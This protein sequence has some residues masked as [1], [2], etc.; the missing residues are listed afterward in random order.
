MTGF[1]PNI[2]SINDKNSPL[3]LLEGYC[4]PKQPINARALSLGP[5]LSLSSELSY[6]A[7]WS[8]MAEIAL[9][10]EIYKQMLDFS[11]C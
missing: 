5:R 2:N 4:L 3:C 7:A 6:I 8:K 1:Q 9:L 10:I 11:Y